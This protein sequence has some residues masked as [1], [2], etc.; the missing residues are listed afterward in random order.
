[1]SKKIDIIDIFG[2]LVAD[3]G[4]NHNQSEHHPLKYPPV[5]F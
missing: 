3:A 2:L 1:M 5:A 4:K